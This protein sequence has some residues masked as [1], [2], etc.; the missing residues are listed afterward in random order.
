MCRL[1]H[2]LHSIELIWALS[3]QSLFLGNP[4]GSKVFLSKENMILGG[5][6]NFSL[7]TIEVW[8]PRARADPLTYFFR[9]FISEV[10]LS[11]L[12]PIKL[13][14]TWRNKRM[15]EDHIAKHSGSLFG[16]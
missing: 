8:G 15:G 1:G 5:D 4:K 16:F 6:L 12:T 14:P 13:G 2:D 7:G 9:H 10:G 3:R 11:D